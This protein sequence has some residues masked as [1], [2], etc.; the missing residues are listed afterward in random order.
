MNALQIKEV[1]S[2][3][4]LRDFIYLPAMVHKN[5]S[6]W[7]P[8]LY[9][10][11]WTLYDPK[12]NKSF[13]HA[14]TVL[15]VAYRQGRPVGRIMGLIH[16]LYNQIH[17]ERHAR[18]AFIESI[19]DREVV[20]NLLAKAEEWA[21]GHGMVKIVGPLGFSDKDPQGLVVSGFDAPLFFTS[22]T[23][24]P[25]LPELVAAEGYTKKV[26]LVNYLLPIPERLP[27]VYNRMLERFR[28][29][30]NVRVV[31]FENKKQL[32]PYILPVLE[33]M[34]QTY[35]E[36]YGYYPLDDEE[37]K[38][39][40]SRYLPVLDPHFI[41]VILCGD[42]VAAF[43]VAMPDPSEGIRKAGG[44]LLP[45]GIFH[46]LREIKRTDILLT[47]LGGIRKEYREQGL[48][49]LMAVKLYESAIKYGIK[50]VNSHLI[51]ETNTRMRGEFERVGGSVSKIFRIFQKD[52]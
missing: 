16:R 50:T 20:H 19:N 31:E 28:N 45:F 14:D 43:A 24:D 52:I 46:I 17:N 33:V 3:R 32:R 21:R 26:D 2:R 18:F 15:Y 4:D 8:P 22:A 12:K 49:V 41:K 34:N 6:K 1:R 27:E 37:K 7:L 44:K 36:I 25:Y 51:L 38:D 10:D 40:A 39:L 23:N 47:M 48:D 11:E 13:K 30:G 9:A 5:D 29:S 42:D 35:M